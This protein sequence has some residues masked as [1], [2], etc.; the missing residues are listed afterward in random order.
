MELSVVLLPC[1]SFPS[2]LVQSWSFRA[3]EMSPREP[4]ADVPLGHGQGGAGWFPK[5]TSLLSITTCSM[6]DDEVNS[7]P[8]L[9]PRWWKVWRQL[10]CLRDHG[11]T[12]DREPTC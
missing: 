11:V 8:A 4:R 6:A 10:C 1:G 7:R 9:W 5:Y 3:G 12:W 2:L